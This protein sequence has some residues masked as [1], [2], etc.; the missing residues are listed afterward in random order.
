MYVVATAGHVDHGKS[1]L[2]RALTGMEPDRW[3]EEHR[4][5]MTIDLGFAWTGLSS[6]ATVAFV[7]VPG[8]EGFVPNM[9]A[10]VGTVPAV[11]FVVAADEGWMPQSR[12]H[13]EALSALGV[14]DGLLVVTRSDLMDPEL[15]RDEAL[16]HLAGSSLGRVPAVCV[17][18]RTGSGLE[19]LRE[20]LDTMLAGLPAA[21]VDGDVRLWVDRAFTI[22][23]AGTVVTGT[24]GAG[25]LGVGD[26]FVLS[27]QGRRVSVR[28]LQC[29]GERVESVSATARV[30]VNLRGVPRDAV[31][32]GRALL[33]PDAWLRTRILDVGLTG[34]A[35]ADLPRQVMLHAGTAAVQ[36]RVRPLGDDTARLSLAEPLPLRIGDRALVRD[37]GAGRIPGAVT[38]LDVRPPPLR[39]RGAAA[40]R[41]GQ[42]ATMAGKPDGAGELRRRG[43]VLRADLVAMGAQVPVCTPEA[44][45]WLVD[46][47]V[48]D[49]RAALL[50]GAVA[51]HDESNPLEPGMPVETARQL[52]GMPEA[53]L[54]QLLLGRPEAATLYLNNGRIHRQASGPTLPAQ[55]RRAVDALRGDL[56][57]HPFAAPEAGRLKE[58]GLGPKQLAAATRSGD[59]LKIAEGVYLA[60]G[61]DQLAV[62]RLLDLPSPFT[63]SQARRALATSRRVIAPLMELLARRGVTR[64]LPDDTH[65]LR[66]AQ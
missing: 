19:E 44:G 54:V 50:V 22:R 35:A 47:D 9:L 43:L 58:L 41:A 61:V 10:G 32:R 37:P 11:M 13:L 65:E 53:G 62:E 16:E 66:R 30:A 4:R 64:R 27:P 63:L 57:E 45:G 21:N 31:G 12:E 24:L 55:V 52:T 14:R 15:A 51:D 7:D 60:P 26:E 39:R 33:T 38:V 2:I 20:A 18:G 23:G 49:S 42:L 29:L 46:P 48:L 40:A 36:A 34:V 56:A 8:H 6:G 3:A 28:G 25:T 17:S 1:T 5:G 59:L